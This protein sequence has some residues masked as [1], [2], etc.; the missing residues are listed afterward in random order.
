VKFYNNGYFEQLHEESIFVNTK[1]IFTTHTPESAALRVYQPDEIW[2][3]RNE[4]GEDLV[5][6]EDLR[7]GRLDLTRRLAD[8]PRVKIINAVSQEHAEVTKLI[9]IPEQAKKVVAV[10]NVLIRAYGR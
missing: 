9:I 6:D 8:N 5:P 4:I 3:L 2:W 1:V 10:T 7:D